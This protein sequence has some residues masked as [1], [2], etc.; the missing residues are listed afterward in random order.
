[1]R[2]L[3]KYIWGVHIDLL[4]FIPTVMK[5]FKLSIVLKMLIFALSILGLLSYINI[6][7]LY[8]II[9][10]LIVITINMFTAYLSRTYAACYMERKYKRIC[11][12]LVSILLSV[13]CFI[14]TCLFLFNEN[15]VFGVSMPIETDALILPCLLLVLV[16]IIEYIPF[17][18]IEIGLN[19]YRKILKT[20]QCS[21]YHKVKI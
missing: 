12:A 9:L 7:K 1:M 19:Q 6:S 8:T 21:I 17:Y 18:L 11:I 2:S 15:G 10:F 13:V 4:K 14:P 16:A 5:Y 20:N 3:L